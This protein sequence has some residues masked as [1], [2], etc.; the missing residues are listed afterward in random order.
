MKFMMVLQQL[1]QSD[2]YDELFNT[3]TDYLFVTWGASLVYSTL[4]QLG[5]YQPF[6]IFSINFILLRVQH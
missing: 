3:L 1:Q 5:W 6:I 4:Q 2:T